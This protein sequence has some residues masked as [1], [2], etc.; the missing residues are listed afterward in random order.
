MSNNKKTIKRCS[1]VKKYAGIGYK[2]LQVDLIQT[3]K[4]LSSLMRE[5]GYSNEM[6]ADYLGVSEYAV[7]NWRTGKNSMTLDHFINISD[8]FKINALDLIAVGTI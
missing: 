8:L 3:G 4:R 5:H 7:K 2:S 1:P 6:L